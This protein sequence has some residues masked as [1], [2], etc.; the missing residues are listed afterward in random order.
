[1]NEVMF[2]NYL[3]L[4]VSV[5]KQ[6]MYDYCAEKDDAKAEKLLTYTDKDTGRKMKYLE[7][8]TIGAYLGYKNIDPEVMEEAF[9]KQRAE[10]KKRRAKRARNKKAADEN[11]Q[12][13][14]CDARPEVE[15]N[16]DPA[17]VS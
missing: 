11:V 4:S 14:P 3:L 5:L 1:M 2:G 16:A 6:L 8:G 17:D 9:R 7:N 12:P 13:E 15:G 10:A